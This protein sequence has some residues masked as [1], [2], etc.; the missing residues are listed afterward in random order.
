MGDKKRFSVDKAGSIRMQRIFEKRDWSGMLGAVA[1]V[2]GVILR[3]IIKD[4]LDAHRRGRE[5]RAI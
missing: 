5:P 3:E 4:S 2:G 1:Q